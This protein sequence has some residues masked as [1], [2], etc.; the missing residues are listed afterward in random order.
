MAEETWRWAGATSPGRIIWMPANSVLVA[1]RFA[2]QR[3][4]FQDQDAALASSA[5]IR[6]PD[7]MTSDLTSS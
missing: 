5:V 4:V 7:S 2:V 3:R 6:P 1:L